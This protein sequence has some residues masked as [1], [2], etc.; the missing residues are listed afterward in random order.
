MPNFSF[1]SAFLRGKLPS[2]LYHLRIDQAASHLGLGCL[3]RDQHFFDKASEQ[4]SQAHDL[5]QELTSIEDSPDQQYRLGVTLTIHGEVLNRRA[6]LHIPGQSTPG[7]SRAALE[8]QQKAVRIFSQ[9]ECSISGPLREST[10]RK[11]METLISMADTLETLELHEESQAA[12]KEAQVIGNRALGEDN[13]SQLQLH[14]SIAA[15]TKRTMD[16]RRDLDDHTPILHIG[17]KICLHGLTNQ[18]LNGKK[19]SV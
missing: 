8:K 18:A 12:I 6:Q 3:Y 17:S 4:L 1:S 19:R 5:I 14:Q 7:D 10:R 9:L 13:T 2:L 15:C 16:A 11:L